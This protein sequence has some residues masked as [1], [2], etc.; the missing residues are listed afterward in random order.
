TTTP[1]DPDGDGIPDALEDSLL[2]KYTP[3]AMLAGTETAWPA[4]ASWIESHSDIS[5]STAQVL[6]ITTPL[7]R[8]PPNI[9]AGSQDVHDWT[10]YGHAY[11]RQGGG[12]VLQYWLYF[13]FNK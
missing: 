8:F 11:P 6:G 5:V 13:P 2:R 10:M 12:I 4:S 7:H 3:S 9:L 1:T